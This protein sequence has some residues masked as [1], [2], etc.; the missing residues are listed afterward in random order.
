MGRLIITPLLLFFIEAFVEL[1]HTSILASTQAKLAAIEKSSS[2]IAMK[3]KMGIFIMII[4]LLESILQNLI[5]FGIANIF[6]SNKSSNFVKSISSV[7]ISLF[8]VFTT[9]VVKSIALR[10]P[11]GTAVICGSIFYYPFII[12]SP[13]GNLMNKISTRIL[14]KNEEQ[15]D[16][17]KTLRKEIAVLIQEDKE[18]LNQMEELKMIQRML[19]LRENQ[20]DKIMTHRSDF[21]TMLDS[22][23]R[24]EVSK[25]ISER[26]IE[27]VKNL[28]LVDKEDNILGTIRTI[29]LLTSQATI[30]A[31]I[32]PP[33]FVVNT[34]NLYKVLQIFVKEKKDILFV[35]DE[36]GDIEG[37]VTESDF[38]TEIVGKEDSEEIFRRI[39]TGLVVSGSFNIRSL[40]REM[41]WNLPDDE[42]TLGGLIISLVQRIPMIH[43]VVQYK[44]FKFEIMESQPNK[45]DLVFIPFDTVYE[46]T[47]K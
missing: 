25:Q 18:L 11:E 21:I 19:A 36:Y 20:V 31:M 4:I 39:P 41:N 16:S 12:L 34:T 10:N 23:D 47:T 44:D 13:V 40:N 27:C 46:I 14:G 35:V 5:G 2:A 7:F 30:S 42:V 24:L 9:M 43:E 37:L 33:V 28:I 29:D 22:V 1:T 8:S 6:I 15:I 17:F 32:E 38:F 3:K 45:I 26:E